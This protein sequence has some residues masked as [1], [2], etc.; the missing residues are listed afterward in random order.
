MAATTRQPQP[1]AL[2]L[3]LSVR[4]R[5]SGARTSSAPSPPS[6]LSRAKGL[7]CPGR[8]PAG[9]GGR[10]SS[11]RYDDN[12]G[13]DDDTMVMFHTDSGRDRVACACW[14]VSWH[15]PRAGGCV[16]AA[17][18]CSLPG[19]LP[20][21]QGRLE[22]GRGRMVGPP[23]SLARSRGGARARIA[24]RAHAHLRGAG[25]AAP[26][27]AAAAAGT[28]HAPTHPLPAH[29]PPA[30]PPPAHPH[31]LTPPHP[32]TPRAPHP[33]RARPPVGHSASSSS[34]RAP[35]TAPTALGAQMNASPRACGGWQQQGAAG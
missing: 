14:P 13:D 11:T 10:N 32:P 24:P 1:H 12:N 18:G 16:A 9:R 4:P 7:R 35:N 20:H 22:D 29:P 15:A 6:S 8:A 2:P 26:A 33:P 30:R 31:P 21:P 27:P 19:A 23:R 25:P 34:C 5:L 28:R 3:K 17:R